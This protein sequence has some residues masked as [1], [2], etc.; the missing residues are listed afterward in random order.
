MKMSNPGVYMILNIITGERYVGGTSKSF[1]RRWTEH[2]Y[3]LRKG[4][5]GNPPLQEAWNKYGESAFCFVMIENVS[6]NVQEREQYWMDKFKENGLL[7]Y[8]RCPSA[9]NHAG[10]IMPIKAV[11][12]AVVSRTKT[13]ARWS[14]ERQ[15][16]FSKTLKETWTPA[17]RERKGKQVKQAWQSN[18][19]R[20]LANRRY[21]G[22]YSFRSPSGEVV[23]V[24]HL[25][26]FCS[27][28]SLDPSAMVKVHRGIRPSHKKWTKAP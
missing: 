15:R 17:R 3:A 18:R 16:Q 20:M 9:F 7:L 12:R 25:S 23:V 5:N 26:N 14:K 22:P 28:Y 8:N 6:E 4:K 24:E 13:R 10:L 19:R 1:S 21:Y 11:A 2:K 27:Q